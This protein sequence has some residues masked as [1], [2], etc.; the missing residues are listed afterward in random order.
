MAIIGD[1]EK[2]GYDVI[3]GTA[4]V[5]KISGANNFN[6]DENGKHLYV[7]KKRNNEYYIDLI[8]RRI[9]SM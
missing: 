1:E 3:R 8:H 5:D 2:G 4:S 9:K 7:V 6:V